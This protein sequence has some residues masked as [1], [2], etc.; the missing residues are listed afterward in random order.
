MKRYFLGS[1]CVLITVLGSA[2]N[3][4]AAPVDYV[5]VCSLYGA[6]FEYVPGTDYC[7]NSLTGDT[8]MQTVGGTWRTLLPYPEGNWAQQFK[9]DCQGKVVKVGDFVSTDFVLNDWERKE[10]APVSLVLQPGQFIVK[11]IMGGG[12]YDPRI[13]SQGGSNGTLG[14]CLR[15]KDPTVFLPQ[16]GGPPI[17]PPYGNGMLP[18]GCVANSRIVNMPLPYVITATAAYPQTFSY[19]PT[20]DQTVVSGPHTYGRQL[21]VTTDIGPGGANLLTYH[22]TTDGI[23]K[24]MAG[25]LNVYVCLGGEGF[26]KP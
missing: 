26:P 11:V 24:P 20:D 5:K 16:P 3:T 10:T 22:D 1:F 9:R 12:F 14:L 18:I 17:N 13:P 23:D 6:G 25:T 4:S 7:W 8:R 21:V 15:S 2:S 19:F